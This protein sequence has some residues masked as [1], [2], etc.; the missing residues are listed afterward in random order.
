MFGKRRPKKIKVKCPR[1]GRK[2]GTIGRL[3]KHIRRMHKGAKGG[4]G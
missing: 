2:F 1:C 4:R 3:E